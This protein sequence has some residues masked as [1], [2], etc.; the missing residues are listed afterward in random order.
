MAILGH[1]VIEDATIREFEN[2]REVTCD[3]ATVTLTFTSRETARQAK[4]AFCDQ[5]WLENMQRKAKR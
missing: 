1:D 5:I 4:K 3:G 2:V